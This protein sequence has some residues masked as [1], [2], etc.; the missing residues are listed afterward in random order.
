MAELRGEQPPGEAQQRPLLTIAIPTFNRSGDLGTLLRVLLPQL[1]GSALIE[2]LVSDNAS[3]DDTEVLVRGF[4]AQGAPIR[5]LRQAENIGSDRN[6]VECF[7]QSQGTFFWLCGDDDVI[8]PGALTKLLPHLDPHGTDLVYVASYSFT[9][10][11][12]AERVEDPLGRR[13][14]TFEDA[15]E[16][17]RVVNIMFTFISGLVVNRD[18]MVEL[19]G[20]KTANLLTPNLVQLNWS[21]PLLLKHRRSVVL[22]DRA[23]AGRVGNAGGYDIGKVFGAGLRESLARLLPERKDLQEAIL[24]PTLRRWLPSVLYGMRQAKNARIGLATAQADFAQAYGSNPR[25]W[26]FAYPV[27][28]LPLAAARLW[29]FGSS[30]VSHAVYVVTVPRFWRKEN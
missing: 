2:L 24:N 13:F 18:R 9:Q 8:C 17:A 23:L 1:D 6:F 29:L 27:M 22:W 12:A 20:P 7:E 14:Q 25:F 30:L 19:F 11:Y 26:M 4:I 28:R 21:L 3:T 15:R 5:Y 10:D 16:F